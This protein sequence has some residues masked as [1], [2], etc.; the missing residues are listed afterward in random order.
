MNRYFRNCA[1]FFFVS[2]FFF[3]LLI[4]S[5]FYG[6]QLSEIEMELI[7]TE[8]SISKYLFHFVC[9]CTLSKLII[10][11][12]QSGKTMFTTTS[13]VRL[14]TPYESMIARNWHR[15][16]ITIFNWA[17]FIKWKLFV[18]IVGNIRDAWKKKERKKE[19]R[20]KSRPLFRVQIIRLFQC[21]QNGSWIRYSVLWKTPSVNRTATY[22]T[23]QKNC[24]LF[25][26]WKRWKRIK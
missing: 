3:L 17:K 23:G 15:Y 18:I 6:E 8:S 4:T 2:L 5:Y 26:A 21:H 7:P 9:G 13:F 25:P 22:R 14:Y 1:I 11:K 12:L 19:E 10:N 20:R 24:S 16:A